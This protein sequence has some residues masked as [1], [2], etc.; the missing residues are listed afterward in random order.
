MSRSV[1]EIGSKLFQMVQIYIS[2]TWMIFGNVIRLIWHNLE[3]MEYLTEFRRICSKVPLTISSL[4]SMF[5]MAI[6]LFCVN[7]RIIGAGLHFVEIKEYFAEFFNN[8][9]EW[10]QIVPINPELLLYEFEDLRKC[11]SADMTQSIKHRIL[12]EFHRTCSQVA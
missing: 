10:F 3:N 4:Q 5:Q 7:L 2:M 9:W 11:N 12:T 1:F 8:S 6:K